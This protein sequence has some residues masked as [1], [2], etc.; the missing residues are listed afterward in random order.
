MC[1]AWHQDGDVISRRCGCYYSHLWS[2]SDV[3]VGRALFLWIFQDFDRHY[4][5]RDLGY[6]RTSISTK[7]FKITKTDINLRNQMYGDWGVGLI[8]I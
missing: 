8:V 4:P 7:S 1:L 2:P 3:F 6:D 5:R